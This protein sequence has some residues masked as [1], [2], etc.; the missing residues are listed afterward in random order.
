MLRVPAV[1][2]VLLP[3]GLCSGWL[4]PIS[5]SALLC[6]VDVEFGDLTTSRRRRLG[7]NTCAHGEGVYL[8][9]DSRHHR[10]FISICTAV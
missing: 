2:P 3:G 4:P 5:A 10:Q 9:D 6:P 1:P 8:M 7:V